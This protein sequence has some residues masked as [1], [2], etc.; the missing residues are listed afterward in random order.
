VS[1]C[2]CQKRGS[3]KWLWQG[4]GG[5]C[6]KQREDGEKL[7]RKTRRKLMHT[8]LLLASKTETLK[9]YLLSLCRAILQR[10]QQQQQHYLQQQKGKTTTTTSFSKSKAATAIE[11]QN[12]TCNLQFFYIY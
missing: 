3:W 12:Q 1:V 9:L 8:Y 4:D 5:I 11:N 2:V 7:Q 10:Q 6:G